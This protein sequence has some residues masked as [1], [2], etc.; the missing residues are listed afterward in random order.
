ML[1]PTEKK[2]RKG[3]RST[4]LD[5]RKPCESK[6]ALDREQIPKK[7]I[8]ASGGERKKQVHSSCPVQRWVSV[9]IQRQA[10]KGTMLVDGQRDSTL[11]G[12][13]SPGFRVVWSSHSGE[14][15]EREWKKKKQKVCAPTLPHFCYLTSQLC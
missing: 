7:F 6:V 15:R 2:I 10:V 8:L 14:M 9:H 11:L 5:L 1:L 4:T 3:A 12:L 13:S